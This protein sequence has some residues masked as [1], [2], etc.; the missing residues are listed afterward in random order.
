MTLTDS[1]FRVKAKNNVTFESD[2]MMI[3]S[4]YTNSTGLLNLQKGLYVEGDF[5]LNADNII[6]DAKKYF[7][8]LAENVMIKSDINLALIF[9]DS[10]SMQSTYIPPPG[11][12]SVA[13]AINMTKDSIQMQS[14]SNTIFG[15][16]NTDIF[17]LESISIAAKKVSVSRQQG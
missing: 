3:N 2:V 17:A 11:E 16:E 5:Y 12:D 6:M 10:L 1:G 13:T 8:A 4:K 9:G 7:V 14:K 15:Y